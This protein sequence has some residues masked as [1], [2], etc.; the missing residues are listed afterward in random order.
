MR[1]QALRSAAYAAGYAMAAEDAAEPRP[2][3]IQPE[4]EDDAALAVEAPRPATSE[5]RTTQWFW[6][7]LWLR[8]WFAGHWSGRAAA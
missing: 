1:M 7:R 3:A 2:E 4:R 5:T 8:E 6:R